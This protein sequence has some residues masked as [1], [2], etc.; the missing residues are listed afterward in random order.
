MNRFVLGAAIV[1]AGFAVPA[2][3]AV[4]SGLQVGDSAGVFHVL[5]VTGPKKGQG[6]H[7]YR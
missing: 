5:D 3:A 7:C 1:A 6:K 2:E 4:K